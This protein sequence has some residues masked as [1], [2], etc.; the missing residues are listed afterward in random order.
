MKLAQFTFICNPVLRYVQ[1]HTSV[2]LKGSNT[3]RKVQENTLTEEK[4]LNKP[5]LADAVQSFRL[6]LWIQNKFNTIKLIII[7]EIYVLYSLI[8]IGAIQSIFPLET[9]HVPQD[10]V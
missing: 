4:T 7:F 1:I 6:S 2:N 5:G 8:Q 10:F 9:I 3:Q